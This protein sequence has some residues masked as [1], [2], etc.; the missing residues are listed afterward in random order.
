M[1]ISIA[2]MATTFRELEPLSPLLNETINQ[3]CWLHVYYMEQQPWKIFTSPQHLLSSLPFLH[4]MSFS[5]SFIF[6]IDFGAQTLRHSQCIHGEWISYSSNINRK[7]KGPSLLIFWGQWHWVSTFSQ[8]IFPKLVS[9]LCNA[10][11]TKLF[12][13]GFWH[14]NMGQFLRLWGFCLSAM[15]FTIMVSDNGIRGAVV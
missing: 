9:S 2:W 13:L 15:V 12:V 1:K 4:S 14:L 7:P 6:I 11:L 3:P 5:L 10:I 8:N